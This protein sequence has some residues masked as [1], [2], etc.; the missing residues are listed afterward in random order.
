[1]S[2]KRDEAIERYMRD[3]EYKAISLY[4]NGVKEGS[5]ETYNIAYRNGL[6]DAWSVIKEAMEMPMSDFER[7]FDGAECLEDIRYMDIGEIAER[8]KKYEAEREETLEA[9]DEVIDINGLKAI[10]TNADTHYHLFYPLSGKTWKAP[11][12]AA[13][14]KTGRKFSHIEMLPF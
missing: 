8:M 12:C 1:M 3:A 10:V 13:L 4:N 5:A 9:G 6:S 14:K 11:K 7:L 2:K